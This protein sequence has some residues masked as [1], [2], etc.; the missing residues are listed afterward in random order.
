M[1]NQLIF[2]ISEELMNPHLKIHGKMAKQ[3]QNNKHV[4]EEV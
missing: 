3:I 1:Y 2:I 4:T